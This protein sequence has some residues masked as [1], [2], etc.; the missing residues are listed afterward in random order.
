MCI[1]PVIR[2]RKDLTLFAYGSHI[3]SLKKDAMM[4]I[5][6]IDMRTTTTTTTSLITMTTIATMT[7]TETTTY[8]RKFAAHVM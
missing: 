5:K 3:N 2:G 1:L 8:L 7:M 6:L 4:M